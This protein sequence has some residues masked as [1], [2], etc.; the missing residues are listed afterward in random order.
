MYKRHLLQRSMLD[1]GKDIGD[2][3][4]QASSYFMQKQALHQQCLDLLASKIATL[5][6]MIN[7]AQQAASEDTKSSAGDKF[8]TSREMM[9]LEINKNSQQLSKANQMLQRL[10]QINPD[11]PKEKIGFGS[12]VLCN[13]G[14]YYFSVGLGKIVMDGENYFALSMASPIGKALVDHQ[15]GDVISFM[16]REIRIEEIL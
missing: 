13:E 15:K 11:I 7:D 3:E 6:Q 14:R 10:Q 8:E 4:S 5:E 12:L 1:K 9:K 2:I 16:K